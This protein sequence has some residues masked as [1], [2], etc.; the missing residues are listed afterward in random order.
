M[1][2]LFNHFIMIGAV[3]FMACIVFSQPAQAVT[4]SDIIKNVT[5][6][7]IGSN[8]AYVNFFTTIPTICA[9]TY[10]AVGGTINDIT[11][12]EWET[13]YKQE[14]QHNIWVYNKIN[15]GTKYYFSLAC[16]DSLGN[17]YE[18]NSLNSA[19]I[20]VYSFTTLSIYTPNTILI[21]G[22]LIK[23]AINSAVYYIGA[24]NRRHLYVNSVT[25]WTWYTGSWSNIKSGDTTKTIKIISQSDFDNLMSGSNVTARP[26]ALI[27]FDNS[28][29]MFTVTTGVK[30]ALVPD[31]ATALQIFGT[32]WSSKVI[33]IQGGFE[34]DYTKDGILNCND[35]INVFWSVYGQLNKTDYITK[36]QDCQQ[37]ILLTN[38]KKIDTTDSYAYEQKKMTF[39]KESGQWKILKTHFYGWSVLK[40]LGAVE[41]EKELQAKMLDSD[42]DGITDNDETC[43]QSESYNPNCVKTDPNKRDT[44]DDGWWD[45]LNLDL[46][47]RI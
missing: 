37:A 3:A 15:P 46:V 41:G 10:N 45:L 44:N 42:Q 17:S 27:R 24:D 23:T 6:S 12:T 34:N 14:L 22:D 47:S 13:N 40:S 28:T 31:T 5:T 38:P 8:G 20:N 21:E 35:D 43:S 29:K 33:I 9:V 30:L 7:S 32:N 2:K 36:W 11:S 25:F 26:G 19:G 18:T 1:T 16:K 4:T 39:I